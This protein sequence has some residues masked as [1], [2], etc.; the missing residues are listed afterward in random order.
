MALFPDACPGSPASDIER[1]SCGGGGRGEG[2][3]R[4][5]RGGRGG[6]SPEILRETKVE[7]ASASFL[8]F[9]FVLEISHF[10][11]LFFVCFG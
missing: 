9:S 8:C 5:G 1:S 11:G 4:G 6:A 3:G 2:G 7:E 10:F